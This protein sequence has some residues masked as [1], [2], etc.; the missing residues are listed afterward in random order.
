MTLNSAAN[1]GGELFVGPLIH[2]F[3][4]DG[5]RRIWIGARGQNTL[6]RKMQKPSVSLRAFLVA[7]EFDVLHSL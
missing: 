6:N 5:L 2:S 1:L 3:A 7:H 4:A